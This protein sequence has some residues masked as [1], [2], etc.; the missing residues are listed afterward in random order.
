[1][2]N[3]KTLKFSDKEKAMKKKKE[4]RSPELLF[5]YRIILYL[6]AFTVGLWIGTLILNR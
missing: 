4:E 6:S 3:N 2:Y 5:L 1:M